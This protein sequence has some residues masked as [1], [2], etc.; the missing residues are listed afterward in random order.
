MVKYWLLL[1]ALAGA[2]HADPETD[3]A[4]FGFRFGAGVI[5]LEHRQAATLSLGL[6]AEHQIAPRWRVL[7]EYEWV[8][9]GHDA[10][11]TMPELR[12]DG[13]RAHV[14]V[15][16]RLG[17]KRWYE[18]AIYADADLGIGFMLANDNMTGMQALPDAF[19][20]VH[21]GYAERTF[22]HASP[23]KAFEADLFVRVLA[24]TDGAGFVGGMGM[25]WQ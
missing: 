24:L 15:R 20:G 22:R 6:S 23:S 7:G 1:A 9:L 2:A 18:M 4:M 5:P 12:G 13:S 8:W 11:G 21:V 14:G 10:T 19:A 17:E 3:R 25:A 16:R